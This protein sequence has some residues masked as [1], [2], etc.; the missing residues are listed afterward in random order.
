V[1][2]RARRLA[3]ILVCSAA[4]AWAGLV[5]AAPW[6]ASLGGV[7]LQLSAASYLTGSVVCHQQAARSFHL[8]GAQLPVCARCTGLYLSGAW[9]LLFGVVL[10]A[11]GAN[12]PAAALARRWSWGRVLVAGTVPMLASVALE[13]VGLWMAPN[14]WRALTAVPAA[15]ALGAMIA[16]FLSFRVKL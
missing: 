9:G 8:A 1:T 11:L 12:E 3:A 10:R 16:E 13:S 7:G 2:T 14:G 15:W 5:L 4:C 6:L